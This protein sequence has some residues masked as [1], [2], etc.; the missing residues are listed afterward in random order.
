M[1]NT[2]NVFYSLQLVKAVVSDRNDV[3]FPLLLSFLDNTSQQETFIN[4]VLNFELKPTYTQLKVNSLLLLLLLFVC[5]KKL[6]L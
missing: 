2:H 6:N 5:L 4:P 3:L 1:R